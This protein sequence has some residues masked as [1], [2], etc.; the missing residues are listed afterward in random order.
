MI[1]LF[2][3][4]I[5]HDSA[6]V[7]VRERVAFSPESIEDAL[8]HLVEQTSAVESAIMSTCNRTELYAVLDASIPTDV[9]VTELLNWLASHHKLDISILQQCYYCKAHDVCGERV[10]FVSAG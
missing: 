3:L 4:G 6:S 7:E 1:P 9:A 2:V 8:Q 5:N 10:K